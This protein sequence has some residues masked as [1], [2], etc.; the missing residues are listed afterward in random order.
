MFVKYKSFINVYQRLYS[1]SLR[2]YSRKLPRRHRRRLGAVRR[3]RSPAPDW[4]T[5]AAS[6]YRILYMLVLYTDLYIYTHSYIFNFFPIS[7]RLFVFVRRGQRTGRRRL[8][9]VCGGRH[10]NQT[11]WTLSA[12]PIYEFFRKG[13]A[14]LPFL[15]AIRSVVARNSPNAVPW[16]IRIRFMIF[17]IA[18]HVSALADVSNRYPIVIWLSKT[19]RQFC[20]AVCAANTLLS[21]IL[22][23]FKS[24]YLYSSFYTHIFIMFDDKINRFNYWSWYLVT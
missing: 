12:L 16:N 1:N 20:W 9:S 8:A 2:K 19:N 17:S 22:K 3:P 14:F 10:S 21:S 6:G 5:S 4:R 11:E 7:R 18:S 23:H 13:K 24:N 15:S